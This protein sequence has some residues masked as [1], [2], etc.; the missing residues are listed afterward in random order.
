MKEEKLDE[1]VL[2]LQHFAIGILKTD[3]CTH[4]V[5]CWMARAYL[6]AIAEINR[7]YGTNYSAH[8]DK[9]RE[10]FESPAKN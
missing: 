9:I 5:R 4:D 10:H 6:D 2:S 3:S 7:V 1:L 8:I